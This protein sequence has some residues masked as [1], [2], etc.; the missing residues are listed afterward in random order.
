MAFKLRE[1][2]SSDWPPER[3]Q[4][5]GRA[6]TIVLLRVL[7]VYQAIS[8]LVDLFGHC[9]PGVTIFGLSIRPSIRRC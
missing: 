3:K 8:S 5:T 6:G 7:T 2:S 9:A 1:A 4:T